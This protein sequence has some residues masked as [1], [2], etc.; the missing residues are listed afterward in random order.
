[1][2]PR[3]QARAERRAAAAAAAAAKAAE[4]AAAKAAA[5][6]TSLVAKARSV[7]VDDSEVRRFLKKVA[8]SPSEG[9]EDDSFQSRASRQCKAK[10]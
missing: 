8:Q 2:A 4:R 7:Q 10:W 9:E 5:P 6:E 3:G 1:M